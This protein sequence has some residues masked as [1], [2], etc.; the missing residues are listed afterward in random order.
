MDAMNETLLL[1]FLAFAILGL[2]V[3]IMYSHIAKYSKKRR[4]MQKILSGALVVD[5]REPS[6]FQSGHYKTAINIPYEEINRNISQLG[7]RD[8]P[9][10]LYCH[11]GVR[12]KKAWRNLKDL[13]FTDVMHANSA[14]DFP[15]FST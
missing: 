9:I 10:I 12:S 3:A 15:T 1:I 11:S 2:T 7:D 4:V 8:T 6:E 14:S 5:V 13:G